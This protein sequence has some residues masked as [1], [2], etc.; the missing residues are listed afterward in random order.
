[1]RPI[2][3]CIAIVLL[4]CPLRANAQTFSG[5][6]YCVAEFAGGIS[7]DENKKA[8]RSARLQNENRLVL[9][10]QYEGTVNQ[11]DALSDTLWERYTVTLAA[12]GDPHEASC[13]NDF[14]FPS[15][16]I[17]VGG[18]GHVSCTSDLTIYRFNLRNNR[19]L[20]AYLRGFVDNSNEHTPSV[21][22]G[23]CTKIETLTPK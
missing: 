18:Y 2:L 11:T 22:G 3:K 19:F 13:T 17:L 20:A 9:R 5:S 6:Y 8:W 23:R 21:A 7:Y 10:L 15:K 12:E 4:L 1:M 14:E 16:T